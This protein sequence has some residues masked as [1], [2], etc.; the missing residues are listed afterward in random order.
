MAIRLEGHRGQP[1]SGGCL[2]CRCRQ[3]YAGKPPARHSPDRPSAG[4]P[5]R[6]EDRAVL[7]FSFFFIKKKEQK[8]NP[9]HLVKS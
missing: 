8:E 3:G 6:G 9:D 4:M 1:T 5:E 2:P 7:I